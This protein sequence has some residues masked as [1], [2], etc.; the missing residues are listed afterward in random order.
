MDEDFLTLIISYLKRNCTVEEKDKISKLLEGS[1]ENKR[2]FDEMCDI[3]YAAKLAD[4][5]SE[6]DAISALKAVKSRIVTGKKVKIEPVH[7][8][9]IYKLFRI[10]AVFLLA[11]I[12]GISSI[13]FFGK[14]AKHKGELTTITAPIGSKTTM[15]LPD[16]TRIWLNAGSTLKYTEQ[17]NRQK[18]EVNLEGEAYFDVAKN[19]KLP[20]TVE[21]ADIKIKAIGTA[22]NVKAYP[23]EKRVETTLVKGLVEIERTGSKDRILLKPN[24]K[25]TFF[26]VSLK[27]NAQTN[28]TYTSNHDENSRLSGITGKDVKLNKEINTEKETCWK[29]G[30]LIFDREPLINLVTKLERRYDVHFTFASEKLKSYRYTGTFDDV[31]LEQIMNAMRL[32]SPL[33]YVI[34]EKQVKL[35]E[36]KTNTNIN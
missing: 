6:F 33:D 3:W 9:L 36:K 8:T 30:K 34:K 13:L 26:N 28:R 20:F 4:N 25:I 35:M 23:E 7:K 16:G 17:F 21:A 31:S 5:T 18:R 2:T 11:F 24:Q 19:P 15:T 14:Y 32:S 12:L 27:S 22:F 10:A 29:E 1:K